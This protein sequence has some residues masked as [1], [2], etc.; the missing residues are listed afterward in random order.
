MNK[1][2]Q[3]LKE[4]VYKKKRIIDDLSKRIKKEKSEIDK[5]EKELAYLQLRELKKKYGDD[6]SLDDL[7]KE[8][9]EHE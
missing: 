5:I 7:E 3:R 8:I 9:K 4:K 2:I 1:K 6:F